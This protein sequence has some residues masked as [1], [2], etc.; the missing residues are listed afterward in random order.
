MA[1][2][3]FKEIRKSASQ[4]NMTYGCIGLRCLVS[5]EGQANLFMDPHVLSRILAGNM[6]VTP[7]SNQGG[8]PAIPCAPATRYSGTSSCL[9]RRVSGCKGDS[10]QRAQNSCNS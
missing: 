2:A 7:N 1:A 10:Y 6:Q 5:D 4:N 3:D 8:K 9:P